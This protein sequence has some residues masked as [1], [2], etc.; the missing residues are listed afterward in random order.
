[1]KLI[2]RKFIRDHSSTLLAV[3]IY[4]K[5]LG[6]LD[7]FP[8]L[9]DSHDDMFDIFVLL[10]QVVEKHVARMTDEGAEYLLGY[11]VDDMIE[12]DLLDMGKK[13]WEPIK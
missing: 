4:P 6:I 5:K 7:V 3:S 2:G 11:T 12:E 8:A 13:M 9:K 10:D 1:M